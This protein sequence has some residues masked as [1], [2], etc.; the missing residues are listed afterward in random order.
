M[1]EAFSVDNYLEIQQSQ[2]SLP[3]LLWIHLKRKRKKVNM[4]RAYQ[5]REQIH[6]HFSQNSLETQFYSPKAS[7]YSL[8]CQQET[9]RTQQQP[10]QNNRQK[11][12]S[13]GAILGC[14]S[15]MAWRVCALCEC[16]LVK[17]KKN[18]TLAHSFPLHHF[19]ASNHHLKGKYTWVVSFK[20]Y[21]FSS[22]GWQVLGRQRPWAALGE[23][24]RA[25]P[26]L[27]DWL[28]HRWSSCPSCVVHASPCC[29][30]WSPTCL[31]SNIECSVELV[32]KCHK[33]SL[34][35]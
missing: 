2:P 8:S 19:K 33:G 34:W 21:L 5:W 25:C 28:S 31:K 15:K 11:Y 13:L 6:K 18:N 9:N 27:Q 14:L 10:I 7:I 16:I 24:S 4:C 1:G 32:A 30:P 20:S 35:D 17:K 22:S 29:W 26:L 12:L 3:S 23:C